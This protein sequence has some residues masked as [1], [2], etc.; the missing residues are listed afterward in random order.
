MSDRLD[1][2]EALLQAAR[3][4]GCDYIFCSSGSEWAPVWE[5]LVRQDL[6]GVPGPKYLDLTHE[7]LAV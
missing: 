5:A 4:L 3:D 1:G 7:T 6:S 2:G